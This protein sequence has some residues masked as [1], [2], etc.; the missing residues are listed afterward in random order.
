MGRG[1]LGEQ[2]GAVTG[3]GWPASVLTPSASP[4]TTGEG[5]GRCSAICVLAGCDGLSVPRAPDGTWGLG[6][7]SG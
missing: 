3:W 6:N 1:M 5:K 7:G 4:L 2:Q